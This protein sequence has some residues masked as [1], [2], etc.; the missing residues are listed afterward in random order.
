MTERLLEMARMKGKSIII[1]WAREIAEKKEDVSFMS[2]AKQK[3]KIVE[4][5]DR[6]ILR[7]AAGA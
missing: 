4:I 7:A 6:L 1:R 5:I 2:M 3:K